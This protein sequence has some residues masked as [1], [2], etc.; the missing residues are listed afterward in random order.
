MNLSARTR[1]WTVDHNPSASFCARRVT[2]VDALLKR[3]HATTGRQ[4]VYLAVHSLDAPGLRTAE[5]QA[6]LARLATA[7]CVRMLASVE[8]VN[9]AALFDAKQAADFQWLWHHMPTFEPLRLETLGYES[10]LA[11]AAAAETQASAGVVL[12]MLTQ[13]SRSVRR[14]R[15]RCRRGCR[16]FGAA[17]S[18]DPARCLF[19]AARPQ[20]AG[21]A[22]VTL[23]QAQIAADLQACVRGDSNTTACCNC[24]GVQDA[25]RGA[26]RGLA[27]RG[28]RGGGPEL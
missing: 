6:L 27:G 24:A 26:A 28:R 12:A 8:H 17:S 11:G 3:I 20:H 14:R 18:P 15:G 5:E 10:V 1:L 22:L 7:P 23:Q 9:A 16:G 2:N 4:P 19:P 13:A 25:R 21:H